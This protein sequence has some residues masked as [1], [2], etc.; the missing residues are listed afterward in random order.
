M[1]LSKRKTCLA[2]VRQITDL[3][4][5]GF[6]ELI[7]RSVDWMK[8]AESGRIPVTV[9]IQRTIALE[10]GVDLDWLRAGDPAKPCID[11]HGDPY[12]LKGWH[13][14][15]SKLKSGR[16]DMRFACNPCHWLLDIA[17]IAEAAGADMRIDLFAH[18]MDALLERLAKK[19]GKKISA[20]DRHLAKM[21]SSPE[22]FFW[23]IADR[24]GLADA[25]GILRASPQILQAPWEVKTVQA[26]RN[27]NNTTASKILEKHPVLDPANR[28]KLRVRMREWTDESGTK[29]REEK[30]VVDRIPKP[31][32]A[33][34]SKKKIVP[35][36]STRK[37]KV[38]TSKMSA[39][40]S[41]RGR[42]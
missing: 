30:L 29:H 37:S 8:K 3:N 42:S 14:H 17:A 10:T 19:Y 20:C 27:P 4:A 40:K 22:A 6:G 35:K 2:V 32:E 36:K 15:R 26:R 9:Q 23:L 24:G 34:P 13:S 25:E 39:Q 28:K 33:K 38:R 16:P 1:A 41:R 21:H 12:T 18:E 31:A 5:A 7:G 11:M